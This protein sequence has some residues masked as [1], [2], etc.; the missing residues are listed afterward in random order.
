MLGVAKRKLMRESRKKNTVLNKKLVHELNKGHDFDWEKV[1]DY[2]YKGANLEETPKYGCSALMRAAKE[3][4]L[5]IV[6]ELIN[7]HAD[8]NFQND[9]GKSALMWAAEHGHLQIVKLLIN[10]G[11]N[12][13]AKNNYNWNVLDFA[14]NSNHRT[15]AQTLKKSGA[16]ENDEVC[17]IISVPGLRLHFVLRLHFGRLSV[18]QDDRV[19]AIHTAVPAEAFSEGCKRAAR[20]EVSV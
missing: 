6:Q 2:I 3:G 11:A 1:A 18:A 9:N 12:V 17:L 8:V 14:N 10:Y 4:K 5:D 20:I 19:G 16:I 7:H 13:N 15:V